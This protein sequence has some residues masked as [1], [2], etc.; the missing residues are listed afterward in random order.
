MDYATYIN[1]LKDTLKKKIQLLDTLL[2]ET[3]LQE[4]SLAL[5][6]VDI[7]TFQKCVEQKEILI[8]QLNKLDD[9]FE[10]VYERFGDAIKENKGKHQEDIRELQECIRKIMEKSSLLQ[11][12]EKNNKMKFEHYL[13]NKK[14]EIR[15]FKVSSKAVGNYYKNMSEGYQGEA[16]FL[17]KKK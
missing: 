10:L 12:K 1:I 9:G 15:S 7:D 11:N 8:E 6:E 13:V 5:E 2:E 14:A 17:D 3:N 16:I 4:S